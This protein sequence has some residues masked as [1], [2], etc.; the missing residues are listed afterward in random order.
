MRV[1]LVCHKPAFPTVDGGTF[2]S[3]GLARSLADAGYDVELLAMAGTGWREEA[4]PAPVTQEIVRVDSSVRALGALT[5]LIRGEADAVARY[6]SSAFAGRLEARLRAGD[7]DVV[8]IDG[9]A[10]GQYLPT[11]RTASGARVILRAH[12]DEADLWRQRSR[13]RPLFERVFLGTHARRLRVIERRLWLSVD[14]IAAITEDLRA[15]C[16]EGGARHVACIPVPQKVADTASPLTHNVLHIGPLDWWANRLGL[17]WFLD[18]VW[19]LIRATRPD[20]ELRVAGRG[21]VEFT[22]P[23]RSSGVVADGE[24][25]DAADYMRRGGILVAPTL[26]GSG[27][28]VKVA[29]GLSLGKAI[30][31]TSVGAR[32]LGVRPSRDLLIEDAPAAFAAAVCRL[33]A[34]RGLADS[35][36]RSAL[37]FARTRLDSRVV[38]ARL[39]ALYDALPRSR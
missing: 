10:T 16:A 21:S 25:P 12:N 31:A 22:A 2:D 29:Q 36:G 20:M 18:S 9:T 39:A 15:A 26:Q 3:A 19:P 30:V 7:F 14:G 23:W 27:M 13:T 28:P 34:D 33:A 37:E 1:L 24:V 4:S 5:T 8:Q 32:G 6:R 11:I 38:A 17:S 35:L